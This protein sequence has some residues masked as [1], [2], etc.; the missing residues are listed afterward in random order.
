MHRIKLSDRVL[1]HYTK[2]EETMNVVTHIV[3]GALAVLIMLL[4]LIRAT[5]HG[6]TVDI[7]GSAIYGSSMVIMYAVSSVYHGL[8]PSIGKK[9]MQI[10]DHC[11]IYFLISGT[12]TPILLSSFI[13]SNPKLGWTLLVTEW[14][15]AALAATLTAIDLHHYK[16]FSM[17]CYICMGWAIV[18]FTPLTIRLL[19]Q[20][21]FMLLLSGGITYSI[22]AVLYGI[23]S[24]KHWVHSIFHI[25]VVMGS[26]LQFFSIIFYVL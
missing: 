11:T 24:K 8:R 22:G 16:V 13:P 4:C 2:R 15:L 10:V 20:S 17:I 1:P 12:Y 18:F 9:V 6:N 26:L 25:F 19:T 23:G 21:G 3:G 14:G 5:T 7:V